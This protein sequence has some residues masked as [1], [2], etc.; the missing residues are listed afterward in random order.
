MKKR[1]LLV[2]PLHPARQQLIEVIH[3]TGTAHMIASTVRE[4]TLALQR[5]TYDVIVTG[6]TL[7]DGSADDLLKVAR[8]AQRDAPVVVVSRTAD[9]TEY[10]EAIN[11]GAF[12]L[13]AADS[14]ASE[15]ARIISNALRATRGHAAGSVA[16]SKDKR[17][18]G[19]S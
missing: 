7:E 16:R 11:R 1:A 9:W 14:P 18:S 6:R 12:D 5:G 2:C 8:Q 4:A 19:R 13:L 17:R 10:L 3:R 15:S